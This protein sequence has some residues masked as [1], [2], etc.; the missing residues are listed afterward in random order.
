VSDRVG[1][2]GESDRAGFRAF[3]DRHIL[4]HA[5]QFD[6]QESIPATVISQMAE[7][8]Y[9]GFTLPGRYGGRDGSMSAWG[10]LNEEIGRG[11]SS[12][13][14]LLTV[15][16]MAC[17][18]ILRWTD[19]AVRDR[20]LPQ[21]ASGHTL[22][23]VAL[24]EP[25]AGSDMHAIE[26]IA[27]PIE[28]GYAIDGIKK[29]ISFGQVAGLFVVFA[30]CDNR[31]AAFLVDRNTPGLTFTPIAGLLGLR[32]SML[33][34]MRLDGCRVPSEALVGRLGF[35]LSH[36][37][38]TALDLGRYSVAC[39]CVGIA[40]GCVEASTRYAAER[41][42]S[43]TLLQEHQLIRRMLTDMIVNVRAARL[44]CLEAGRLK[45]LAD[46][47]AVVQTLIAKYFSARAAAR[48]AR[49]AVQIHG[50]NG[51]TDAYPVARYFRDAKIME[52]IEGSDEIQQ[53]TIAGSG[54]ETPS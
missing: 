8:G 32:G 23:A 43:G 5:T 21:L 19:Q 40:Q 16:G 48:S 7:A 42:Q 28:D 12:V 6:Q 2:T 9:L 15:H 46:P 18:T 54:G 31:P 1:A 35:G 50:A 25:N 24:S 34:E 26:T 38:A 33:A 11:C 37:A 13:R 14:S 22:G 52:I 53:V 30:K 20:W 51:C 47:G 39:G 27:R 45:D 3:V 36:V 41:K 29:W 44:L 4:P 17:H 10:V 49:D